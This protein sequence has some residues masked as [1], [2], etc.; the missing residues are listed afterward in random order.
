M[1]I[2]QAFDVSP[3]LL[4]RFD[5]PVAK[6]IALEQVWSTDLLRYFVTLADHYFDALELIILHGDF[7]LDLLLGSQKWFIDDLSPFLL[8]HPKEVIGD[9]LDA[10]LEVSEVIWERYLLLVKLVNVS[11]DRIDELDVWQGWDDAG[12][13]IDIALLFTDQLR[14]LAIILEQ[15]IV[16]ALYSFL[17]IL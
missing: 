16:V 17:R 13:C 15:L 12:D 5:L 8:A 11:A 10:S 2:L 7:E 9:R 3:F 6:F 14:I 4:S 1:L